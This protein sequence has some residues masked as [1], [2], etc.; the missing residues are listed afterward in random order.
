MSIDLHV[1][2]ITTPVPFSANMHVGT[3]AVDCLSAT[4]VTTTWICVES[5]GGCTIAIVFDE[6]KLSA[7]PSAT[8]IAI[9]A[10]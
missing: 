7:T 3:D 4:L 10:D 5:C 6:V 9:L 8:R 2:C 1:Q